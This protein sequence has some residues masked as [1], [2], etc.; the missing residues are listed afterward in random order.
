[1]IELV[2]RFEPAHI[3]VMDEH[4]DLIP[5]ER[6]DGWA[7]ADADTAWPVDPVF[8]ELIQS[9]A[10]QRLRRI[11]FLGAIDFLFHPNGKPGC[12]RHNRFD[13]SLA[14]GRLADQYC[15]WMGLADRERLHLVAAALLHD[16][17][18]PPLSHSLEPLFRERFGL[19]HH[20][21]GQ[22]VI[23]GEGAV[24]Q[25]I[26]GILRS[27]GLD[28]E[29]VIAL[30]DHDLLTGPINVDTLD[31]ILRSLTY[32]N[33]PLRRPRPDQ[34]LLASIQRHPQDIKLIDDF[35]NIKREVYKLL[36]N[37]Y[38]GVMADFASIH[39]MSNM[40]VIEKDVLFWDDLRLRKYHPKLF[41][42]LMSIRNRAWVSGDMPSWP[43]QIKGALRV[44]HVDTSAKLTDA[45]SFKMRY[46]QEKSWLW[47]PVPPLRPGDRD[48]VDGIS[49][50]KEL[51]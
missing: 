36:I 41:C 8:V 26:P 2:T 14:V 3:R 42:L 23:R 1:M 43:S 10:L 34:V 29:R 7:D 50:E 5:L 25:D 12:R 30:L 28:P 22:A 15:R 32:L 45:G 31:G 44:F 20:E 13:H 38:Y 47:L 49:E 40:A 18:H 48:H 51:F 9:D 24:G 35:W 11:H 21:I 39:Y 27:F 4:P 33:P 19:G 16:I 17:G 46:R 6:S 37:G